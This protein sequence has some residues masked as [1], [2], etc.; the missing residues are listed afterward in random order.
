MEY[1]KWDQ[2]MYVGDLKG[3][4]RGKKKQKTYMNKIA[5]NFLNIGRDVDIQIN[6][7]QKSPDRIDPN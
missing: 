4:E 6:K 3:E 5:E 2:Y 1:H 7:V